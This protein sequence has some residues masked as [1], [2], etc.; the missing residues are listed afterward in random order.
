MEDDR[1]YL[2]GCILKGMA[3]RQNIYFG[4]AEDALAVADA[5]LEQMASGAELALTFDETSTNACQ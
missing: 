5:V 4:M 2:V 1:V 3:S